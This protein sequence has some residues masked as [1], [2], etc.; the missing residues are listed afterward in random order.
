MS[1][2]KRE[3][4]RARLREQKWTQRQTDARARRRRAWTIAGAVSGVAVVAGVTVL[5]INANTPDKTY[6]LAPPSAAQDRAWTGELRT[7]AGDVAFTLDG[8]AAPQ[9]VA[10]FVSLA[11]DEYFDGTDCH[12]LTTEGI[13]ILQCG[14]PTGTGTGGPGYDF[15]PVENAPEDGLYPAGT[16]AMART[17]AGTDTMGSQFFLVYED[18]T[19]PTTTGGYTVFGKITSGLDVVR[20]VADAGTADG[21]GNGSPATPVTIE[22]VETQ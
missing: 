15:G 11:R 4:E 10:N 13:F 8:Q 9:A 16:I 17:E 21:T 3:R 7:S 2:S 14:D 1:T 12:R 5:A 6:T 19:L 22:G 20:A 18:T